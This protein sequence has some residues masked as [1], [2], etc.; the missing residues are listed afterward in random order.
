MPDKTP[1]NEE[2]LRETEDSLENQRIHPTPDHVPFSAIATSRKK[3]PSKLQLQCLDRKKKRK[4][5]KD[6]NKNGGTIHV[7]LS[8]AELE[9]LGLIVDYLTEKYGI[10]TRRGAV[11]FCIGEFIERN[12]LKEEENDKQD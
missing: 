2:W 11:R 1:V 9:K 8:I 7:N 6:K 10:D 3:K 12:K 5:E 4:A